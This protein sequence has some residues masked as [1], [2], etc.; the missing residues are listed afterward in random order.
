MPPTIAYLAKGRLHVKDGDGAPRVLESQ[1]GLAVRDRAVRSNQLHS[2]KTEG[3][4]AR[5]M[6]GGAMWGAPARDPAAMRI[7]VTSLGRAREPGRLL[8][9]LETDEVAGLFALD[10]KSGEETRLFHGNTFRVQHP[11]ARPEVELVACSVPHEGGTANLAVMRA[12]GSELLEVTEGDSLDLAPAWVPGMPQLV[13]QSAGM[14]R[15]RT[16]AFI[17]YGPFSLHR[18]DLKSGELATVAEDPA[19]D[20]LG[21]RVAA[22]GTVWCIQRPWRAERK[23][24]FLRFLL[25]V[26]L[27]PWRLL[28]ALFS[29]LNFFAVRYTGKPLSSSGDTRRQ[30]ADLERML[31]WGNLIDADKGARRARLKGD[32]APALVPPTWRLV[33]IAPGGAPEVVARG[34][35]AFDLG[36]AGEVVYSNGSAL[37]ALGPDGAA[38]RLHADEQI[39]QV[40]VL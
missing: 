11:A 27:L 4:G 34:V 10:V 37:F 18:I 31:V 28:V 6:S 26:L 38:K 13:Y 36:P 21:P 24:S 16:G 20:F 35:L 29:W 7:A 3:R 5:F 17:G 14:G 1:F 40:V 30:A 12:D 19:A 33:R 9:A 32:E 8:Y 2:W 39:E 15:D 23:L 25:D 22:D